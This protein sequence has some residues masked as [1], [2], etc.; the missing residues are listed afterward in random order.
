MAFVGIALVNVVRTNIQ[1]RA[2]RCDDLCPPVHLI[3]WHDRTIANVRCGDHKSQ[4]STANWTLRT[5]VGSFL[6]SATGMSRD[7]DG[8]DSYYVSEAI[9]LRNCISQIVC[10]HQGSHFVR[11]LGSMYGYRQ[12]VSQFA[13]RY[14]HK[15]NLVPPDPYM[16]LTGD[17]WYEHG[18]LREWHKHRRRGLVNIN[19]TGSSTIWE[20]YNGLIPSYIGRPASCEQ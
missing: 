18:V 20:L 9:L 1:Y 12:P 6:I 2:L 5:A 11:R 19:S 10:G 14:L 17:Q 15:I 3:Q 16:E 7:D 13:R 8:T 4:D